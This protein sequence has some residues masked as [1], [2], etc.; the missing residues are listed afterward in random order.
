MCLS[1]QIYRLGR[2]PD[3]PACYFY[4]LSIRHTRTCSS[5]RS[6]IHAPDSSDYPPRQGGSAGALPIRARRPWGDDGGCPAGCWQLGFD[7]GRLLRF[8][9]G[10]G[11]T[12]G[13]NRAV[14]PIAKA[15]VNQPR[16]RVC[17]LS[18]TGRLIASGNSR[19]RL[20]NG[21]SA[22]PPNSGFYCSTT[23]AEAGRGAS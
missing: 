16:R 4:E 12:R 15:A 19:A 17:R 9:N 14:L 13:R 18:W 6:L 21:A 3:L 7:A 11:R 5:R 1:R 20:G 10:S 8:D 22:E 2:G 23:R